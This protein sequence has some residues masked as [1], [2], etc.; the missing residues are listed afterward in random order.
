MRRVLLLALL[1]TLII[2][3]WARASDA[4]IP[5]P[6]YLAIGG[7]MPDGVPAAAA[8]PL[9]S[10]PAARPMHLALVLA[11]RDEAG[12]V[13]AAAAMYD[14]RSPQFQH[15]LRYAELVRRFG[16][17][18]ARLDVLRAW[19]RSQGLSTPH[20]DGGPIMD[21]DG[22][23]RHVEAAFR[24]GIW[25]YRLGMRTAYGPTHPPMLPARLATLVRGI[26]G[27]SAWNVPARAL[28]PTGIRPLPSS[29]VVSARPSR[30]PATGAIVGYSWADLAR[31]Y[32]F[33]P[34]ASAALR[35][36][37][38]RAALVELGPFTL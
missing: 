6:A 29:A 12:L 7:A 34:L 18:P 32:D 21:I 36:Q 17:D 23:V 9:R 2:P 33:G 11:W 38:M 4:S 31:A 19:L 5:S 15:Y 35:G 20:W 25:N 37:G 22:D 8:T 10:L 3:S 30:A 16:P 27:L 26:V 14:R 1:A 13:A 28:P 24:T